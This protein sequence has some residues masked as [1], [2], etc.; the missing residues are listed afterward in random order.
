MLSPSKRRSGASYHGQIGE[1]ELWVE[2]RVTEESIE[3]I[4]NAVFVS[5]PNLTYAAIKAPI[6]R[7]NVIAHLALMSRLF[8]T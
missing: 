3:T 6:R 7:A 1:E 2:W 8:V 4:R 5:L